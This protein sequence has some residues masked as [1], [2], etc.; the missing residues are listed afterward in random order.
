MANVA[1]CVNP[2]LD[3]VKVESKGYKFILAKDL[4]NSVLN[5]EC[6]ILETYKGSDLVGI[7]YEQLMPFVKV[8]GKS[9]IVL[10]D[11]Y[12]TASDGTGIVHIAPAYGEDDNRV[13]REN[14]IAFI[15]P[16]GKDGKYLTGPWTGY[17][18]TDPNLEIEIIKYLKEND[19][20]F[21]KIK[22]THEYPHC[23]RCKEPLIYYAK[24]AWYVR[25]TE[26][27]DKIIESN[28]TVTWYP[29]FIGQKDL[30]I[31]LKT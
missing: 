21:K 1:L 26:Y 31:G 17:V 2:T 16:V 6:T 13:C 5:D 4:V 23:W 24:P 12:V 7:K 9:F 27:K 20:L 11:N 22:M 28:K 18:V 15:N 29:E 10:A 19:K 25:T 30:I 14:D 3:Y 8:E